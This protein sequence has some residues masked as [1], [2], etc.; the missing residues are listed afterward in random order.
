[1]SWIMDLET[2]LVTIIKNEFPS[3]LKDKNPNILFTSVNQSSD[4]PVFPTV[5]ISMLPMSERGRDTEGDH[6][7]SVYATLQVDVTSNKSKRNASEIADAII[8]ILTKH[9]FSVTTPR[10][11][12]N[13]KRY[14][15]SIR[16]T[17]LIGSNDR[18]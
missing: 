16:A 3:S 12:A 4:S 2:T 5:Y 15:G 1:M 11:V 18:I 9:R 13:N 7:N 17:K 14:S 8:D 10:I 6:I